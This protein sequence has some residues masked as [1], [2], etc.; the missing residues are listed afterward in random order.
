MTMTVAG[1]GSF[2]MGAG[3]ASMH[4]IGMEAMRLPAMCVYSTGLLVL[5]VVLAIVI[6]FVALWLTYLLRDQLTTWGWRKL[7]CALVMGAAIPV[8]HYVGMAAASFVPMPLDPATLRHSINISDLGVASILIATLVILGLVFI[9][10][11]VD[12]RFSLQA[13]ELESSEERY[14]LIVETAF[15]AFLGIDSNNLVTEWNAQAEATFG[16]S[17]TEAIGKPASKFLFLDSRISNGHSLDEML[18]AGTTDSIHRRMEATGVHRGGH[19]FPV[20]MT[21]SAVHQRH[22]RLFAAFVHDVTDRKAA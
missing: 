9:T 3:I 22:K 20:E 6:S 1:A 12:R 16:W 5:S 14:R 10:S 19:Q 2:F 15:D 4:Y 8:M 18:A 13:K 11:I 17:R 7:A 21:V